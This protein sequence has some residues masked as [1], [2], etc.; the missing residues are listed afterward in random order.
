MGVHRQENGGS[1]REVKVEH[2]P[3]FVANKT[4]KLILKIPFLNCGSEDFKK[5]LFI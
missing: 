4:I 2:V 3:V 1:G 5:F